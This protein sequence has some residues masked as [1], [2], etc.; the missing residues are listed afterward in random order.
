MLARCLDGH[1]TST[2]SAHPASLRRGKSHVP[3][4]YHSTRAPVRADASISGGATP[5]YQLERGP[6][7]VAKKRLPRRLRPE[8][9]LVVPGSAFASW[10]RG[11]VAFTQGRSRPS[12]Q[13]RTA[14]QATSSSKTPIFRRSWAACSA[15]ARPA[16]RRRGSRSA[17]AARSRGESCLEATTASRV[18]S[19]T[20]A[21]FGLVD[22]FTTTHCSRVTNQT[23]HGRPEKGSSTSRATS[24]AARAAPHWVD[25]RP[26]NP[27]QLIGYPTCSPRRS[28]ARAERL[29][30]RPHG[31]ER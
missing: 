31:V 24:K 29:R 3:R 27:G 14:S 7:V 17:P 30:S 19:Q 20:N 18:A 13:T 12:G 8:P 5:S 21:S 1:T 10:A 15:T 16:S 25:L 11:I 6:V 28:T 26:G 23:R 9:A 4:L 2:A 22:V